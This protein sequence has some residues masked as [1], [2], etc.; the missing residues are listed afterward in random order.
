M[1]STHHQR[2]AAG[3]W[4][5][6][7]LTSTRRRTPPKRLATARGSAPLSPAARTPAT[8]AATGA[9]PVSGSQAAIGPA[10]VC[11]PAGV[12]ARGAAHRSSR[13]RPRGTS[14]RARRAIQRR[15]PARLRPTAPRRCG[16]CA[17]ALVT[18]TTVACQVFGSRARCHRVQ[19]A[20]IAERGANAG[21]ARRARDGGRAHPTIRHRVCIGTR[22]C[23]RRLTRLVPIGASFGH[24]T[25]THTLS[26][27]L[28]GR[29][30]SKCAVRPQS[31]ARADH[32]DEITWRADHHDGIT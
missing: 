17:A 14:E 11:V 30:A 15:R 26:R 3:L 16:S 25:R 7:H 21:T 1:A 8:C 13:R 31:A 24:G 20:T 5:A 6:R 18:T 23:V 9:A 2:P 19:L 29:E 10:G 22:S 12:R 4:C 27:T 28:A 32:L